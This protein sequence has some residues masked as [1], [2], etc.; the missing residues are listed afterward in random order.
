MLQ[1]S[2]GVA[3]S[4]GFDKGIQADLGDI[5]GSVPE[6]CRKVNIAVK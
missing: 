6:H 2:L 3:H 4:M 5:S 1:F